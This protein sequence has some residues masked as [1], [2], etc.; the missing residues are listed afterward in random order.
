MNFFGFCCSKED[1]E[2]KDAA[3]S[4]TFQKQHKKPALEYSKSSFIPCMS[5]QMR[6]SMVQSLV[7]SGNLV[8]VLCLSSFAR[9]LPLLRHFHPPPSGLSSH[10][11]P[12]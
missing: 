5:S 3:V 10:C 9:R 4:A 8:L 7:V 6:F 2:F 1:S 12:G 11:L